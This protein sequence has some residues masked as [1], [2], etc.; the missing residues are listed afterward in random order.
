MN[1]GSAYPVSHAQQGQALVLALLLIG[2]ALLVLVRY[3][4]VG[5]MVGAKAR[6]LHALDATAYSGALI[7]AR[8]MNMLAY[9]NRAHV[10]HQLAMA[11]LVTLGSWASLGGAQAS[12]LK[13]GNP[14]GYLIAMLFGPDH[15]AA[16]AAASRA[17]GFSGLAMPGA[18]LARAYGGHDHAVRT[19]LSTVQDAIVAELPQARQQA[20]QAVLRQNYP[21]HMASLQFD[22]VLDHDNLPGYVQ[23]QSGHGQLRSLVEDVAQLYGFLSPRNDTAFNNWVVD[24]RCPGLRHQLRRRGST[25][26][27]RQGR[28]QSADTLS[29]HALRS[30]RWIGCYYREYAMGWGWIPSSLTQ[31]IGQPHVDDPPADFAAQDFWRWVQEA[32]NWDITSDNANPLANSRAVASRQRW[33]GG[34]LPSYFDVAVGPSSSSLKFSVS[35]RHPGPDGLMVSTRSAAETFF[36]RP[37]ARRDARNEQASLFHPYWQARLAV[38]KDDA[39]AAERQP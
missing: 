13:S 5:Q 8:A 30:N 22:L 18:E 16:Y 1:A 29:F 6:Q 25:E 32:T 34:G 17:S 10:G 37:E 20:M 36:D 21:E 12:Q 24:A 11:H 28:W 2:A 7:Q 4:A 14:P 31:T 9:I 33:Q 23:R 27:D 3:F 26:L 15:G 38:H 39:N 35:L 19:V